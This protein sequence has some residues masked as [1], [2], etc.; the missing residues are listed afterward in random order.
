MRRLMWAAPVLMAVLAFGAMPAQANGYDEGARFQDGSRGR[1]YETRNDR[2]CR[3][4]GEQRCGRE[5]SFGR[6]QRFGHERN[7]WQNRGRHERGWQQ[8]GWQQDGRQGGWQQD[9]GHVRMR[10]G[11]R[12]DRYGN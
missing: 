9:G 1:A 12:D 7:G 11:G 2:D 8:G 6:E 10:D 3:A 5:Q 4:G